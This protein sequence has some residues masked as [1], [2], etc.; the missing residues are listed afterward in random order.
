MTPAEL[1]YFRAKL[2]VDDPHLRA[3]ICTAPFE[4]VFDGRPLEQ[5]AAL[6][7]A[8]EKFFDLRHR[9]QTTRSR[10]TLLKLAGHEPC[11][12]GDYVQP[13]KRLD[14]ELSAAATGWRGADGRVH[15]FSVDNPAVDDDEPFDGCHHG[16]HFDEPCA[17]C[18][19][20]HAEVDAL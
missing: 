11:E 16:K 17:R 10:S 1:D 8:Q 19:A 7:R 18:D 3:I 14:G 2:L 4:R 5:Q 13:L 6:A 15:R 9:F 12:Q 20:D